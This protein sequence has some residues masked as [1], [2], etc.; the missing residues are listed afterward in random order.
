METVRD[1]KQ[2]LIFIIYIALLG[3]PNLGTFIAFCCIVLFP[4]R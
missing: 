1:N 4:G 3:K 2:T